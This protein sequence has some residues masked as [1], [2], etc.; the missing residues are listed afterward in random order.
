MSTQVVS[1]E[2]LVTGQKMSREE[3]LRQWEQ[4]PDLKNAELIDGVV[5]VSSPVSPDHAFRNTSVI[6]WLNHYALSTPG[7]QAGNN[8]TWTMLDF[9]PQPDSFL[10]LRPEY[11]G[12]S[13]DT[14]ESC[15]GAPELVVEICVTSTEVDFGPKL[16]LYQRAGVREYVTA[17]TLRKRVTWRVLQDGAYVAQ[18]I[19]DDGIFRSPVFPGLWLNVAA[20][21]DDDGSRMMAALNQGL[22]TEEHQR[23]VQSLASYPG[24]TGTETAPDR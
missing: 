19:P 12:Q 9:A 1:A 3:F 10:R 23:F 2:G 7:C 14:R 20:F 5:H 15:E 4:L 24:S 8:M 11:G 22:A 16:R 21:W 17:E 18:R 13:R 6:W